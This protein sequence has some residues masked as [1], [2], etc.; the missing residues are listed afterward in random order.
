MGSG[1]LYSCSA[2]DCSADHSTGSG[3]KYGSAVTDRATGRSD[4][5]T[6]DAT[7]HSNA[8]TDHA[9][10]HSNAGADHST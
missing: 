3:R 8:D 10:G 4:P 5:G 9:T 7:G 1:T 2:V 6:D